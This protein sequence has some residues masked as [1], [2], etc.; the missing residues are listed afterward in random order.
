MVAAFVY[1]GCLMQIPPGHARA[2]REDQAIDVLFLSFTGVGIVQVPMYKLV[3]D[4]HKLCLTPSWDRAKEGKGRKTG[5][6]F[7]KVQLLRRIS[8]GDFRVDVPTIDLI[9]RLT[10]SKALIV[11]DKDTALKLLTVAVQVRRQRNRA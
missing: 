11:R 3:F 2:E 8:D 4:E 1:L 10:V 9:T 5:R 7:L 6:A